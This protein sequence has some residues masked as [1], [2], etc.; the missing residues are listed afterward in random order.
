MSLYEKLAKN[1]KLK[2]LIADSEKTL[3][4]EDEF[5]STGVAVLNILYSGRIDGGI[6]KY[7]IS[8][9][10][11]G[12][13]QGKSFQTLLL[14]KQ[15]LKQN[16]DVIIIDTENA[17]NDLTLQNFGLF[18]YIKNHKLIIIPE[19]D[20]TEIKKIVGNLKEEL[21]FNDR[22]NALLI[23]DSWGGLVNSKQVDDAING[24]DVAD[25]QTTR[26]KNSLAVLL[27]TLHPMTIF[28]VG[29]TYACGTENMKVKTKDGIKSLKDIQKGD[30]VR[31]TNGFE[32]VQNKFEYNNALVYEIELENNEKLE[33]TGEH[34]LLIKRNNEY[35]WVKVEDLRVGNDIIT[36]DEYSL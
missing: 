27:N 1:K 7:K 18:D 30:I 12:S 25:L 13:G 29:H 5:I 28:T 32:I 31:T 17:L 15:A 34:K 9:I 19:N 26:A 2:D 8:M 33:F 3:E 24:K 23:I 36:I 20:I 21:D 14:A 4:L 35:E 16:M 10:A 22:K 6:P 11:G